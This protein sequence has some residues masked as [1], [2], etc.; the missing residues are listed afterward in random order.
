VPLP[1]PND[2]TRP[3]ASHR[4]DVIQ[5]DR[6]LQNPGMLSGVRKGG[7]FLDV[8]CSLWRLGH[9]VDRGPSRLQLSVSVIG[10]LE[11]ELQYSQGG[12][13]RDGGEVGASLTDAS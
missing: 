4:L 5:V 6:H 11:S 10:S 7:E 2:E 12:V 3:D 13:E 1:R 9:A 8:V